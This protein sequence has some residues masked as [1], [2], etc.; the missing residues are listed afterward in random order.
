MIPCRYALVPLIVALVT[1]NSLL[2]QNVCVEFMENHPDDSGW[3]KACI[4]YLESIPSAP[5]PLGQIGQSMMG[6]DS[7]MLHVETPRNMAVASCG[8]TGFA[9]NQNEIFIAKDPNSNR[10]FAISK[11]DS[12]DRLFAAYSDDA[13]CNWTPSYIADGNGSL[14]EAQADPWATFD[15]FGNLW[16]SY[17]GREGDPIT[18]VPIRIARNVD[19]GETFPAD[20]VYTIGAGLFADKPVMAAGIDTTTGPPG[21][22]DAHGSLWVMYV[23]QGTSPRELLVQGAALDVNGDI[24]MDSCEATP[25][26][27]DDPFCP[28]ELI[29]ISDSANFLA[30]SPGDISVGPSGQV[31]VGYEQFSQTSTVQTELYLERDDDG[32]G[33]SGFTD[34]TPEPVPDP[35]PLTPTPDVL[36]N[37]KFAT[38]LPGN[39][40]G[41]VAPFI[42]LDWDRSTLRHGQFG[43][44]HMVYTDA[45]Q[46]GSFDTDIWSSHSDDAGATW[47]PA[48]Q[49]NDDTGTMSQFFPYLAV[50]Q[51][52][53][54]VA[55]AWLDARDDD[56]GNE[57]THLYASVR[58][59]DST[60]FEDNV[61]VS[62]GAADAEPGD[63]HGDYIGVAFDDGI[64][65]PAWMDNSNFYG[66]NADTPP[67]MDPFT[68]KVKLPEPG[69]GLQLLAGVLALWGLSSR[70]ARGRL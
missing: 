39:D 22:S 52:T 32:L 46:P 33:T 45:D 53:G 37:M 49:V 6:M 47:Q 70:R 65:Y 34:A 12:Q 64:I 18:S 23:D 29:A 67:K 43:R 40:G 20:Q 68:A 38:P 50:D 17:M 9:D 2:A 61:R 44:V 36:V 8:G 54:D 42:Y 21:R 4:D 25:G 26:P 13:G 5:T 1:P 15:S 63:S 56:P 24:I 35:D 19:G 27:P 31:L 16:I 3:H 58:L 11:K 30:V 14:P 57:L 69:A 10:V 66:D 28:R 60:I 55:V 51:T 59:N 41:A 7:P 48:I 62:E